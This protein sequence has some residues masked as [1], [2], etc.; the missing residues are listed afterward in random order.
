MPR[1]RFPSFAA[2]SALLVLPVLVSLPHSLSSGR[3]SE[4]AV[5]GV[6]V[7]VSDFE[8]PAVPPQR[9][10]GP[11]GKPPADGEAYEQA[12]RILTT[13]KL[14]LTE[15]L[16]KAGFAVTSFPPAGG[17][18][19]H[20]VLLRGVFTEPDEYNRVRRVILGTASPSPKFV[21]YVGVTN[22]ARPDQPLYQLVPANTPGPPVDTRFGPLITITSYA[23]VVSFDLPR[24]PSDDDLKRAAADI[25][26]HFSALVA[27]N[28]ALKE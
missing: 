2:L 23:P 1:N 24:R 28:P 11:S 27:A 22:L 10:T 7:Y 14:T 5:S 26:S 25:A 20:G 9:P 8:L 18:P 17:R 15:S 4:S 12:R 16:T 6:V 21:L 3:R 13:L 19:D